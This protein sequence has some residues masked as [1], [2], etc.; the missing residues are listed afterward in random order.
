MSGE[1]GLAGYR[2]QYH[3][4]VLAALDLWAQDADH[5]VEALVVEGRPNAEKVDYEVV[6]RGLGNSA[7]VQVKGRWGSRPWSAP[8]IARILTDLGHSQVGPARL[9]LVANGAFSVPARRL[10][11]LLTAAPDHDDDVLERELV[12]LGIKLD[13]QRKDF[14]EPARSSRLTI[15]ITGRHR[16]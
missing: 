10:V 1:L 3:V 15:V 2:F 16:G 6:G 7:V 11:A 9:E 13:P 4:M 14:G 8:E 5:G 12:E